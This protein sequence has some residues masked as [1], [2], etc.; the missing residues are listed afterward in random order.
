MNETGAPQ[1]LLAY[2]GSPAAAEAIAAAGRLAPGAHATVVTVRDSWLALEH[3][4]MTRIA[5]PDSILVP[6][7][8]EFEA[9]VESGAR[10]VAEEGRGLAAAAGLDAQARVQP[11]DTPSRGLMDAASAVHADAIVCGT[12][13]HGGVYRAV[14]GTTA[15]HLLHHAPLPVLIVPPQEEPSD[16]PLLIGYDGSEYAKDAI[17]TAGRLFAERRALI[18]H[19]WMSPMEHSYAGSALLGTPLDEIHDV[20]Q[21]LADMFAAQAADLLDGGTIIARDAGLDPEPLDLEWTHGAWRALE[22]A[23]REHHAA[24]IVAGCRGRGAVASTVLGSVSSGLAH[25]ATVPVLIVRRPSDHVRDGRDE[26]RAHA[27]R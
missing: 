16:G 19:A 8:R 24:A 18:A 17:R 7:V 4:A 20:A 12:S 10:R 11:A 15:G 13:G 21:S 6:A 1:L 9:D 27:Q 14:L 25:N 3:A 26:K 23:A 22:T 2:D 5:L